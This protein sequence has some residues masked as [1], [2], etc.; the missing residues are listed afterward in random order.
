MSKKAI[1]FG[2]YNLNLGDDLFMDILK[3][4]LK[5]YSIDFL[6]PDETSSFYSR[7]NGFSIRHYSKLERRIDRLAYMAFKWCPCLTNIIKPYDVT[8]I[9]GGSLFMENDNWKDSYRFYNMLRLAS[10]KLYVIGCN[11]G[12]YQSKEFL[13]NYRCYF[14]TLNGITVRDNYSK[15]VLNLN[16][17]KAYPDF[18][19]NLDF[20]IKNERKKVL[21]V[22]VINLSRR[23]FT[24]EEK[25]KY[26]SGIIKEC[27]CFSNKGYSIR[28][29][30]FCKAEGDEEICKMLASRIK[31]AEVINY[32]GNIHKFLISF[33]ECKFI[34]ATRFHAVILGWNFGI[35]TLPI[36]YSSKTLNIINDL[37]PGIRMALLKDPKENFLFRESDFSLLEN[38]KPI[39]SKAINHLKFFEK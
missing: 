4:K 13:E 2:Y 19:F 7:S 5:N 21:G 30:S 16:N 25:N 18:V 11:F 35:P 1:I 36:V 29:F 31:N 34:I 20:P 27:S 12:P 24:P 28:L 33:S 15:K 17:V 22:S 32:D 37:N 38:I 3:R 14:N 6:V 9:L 8:I 23:N 10:K 39:R 26:Y